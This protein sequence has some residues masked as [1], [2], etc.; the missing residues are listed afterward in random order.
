[1]GKESVRIVFKFKTT[2]L[3]IIIFLIVFVAHAQTFSKKNYPQ[4]YFQWPVGAAIGLAANFGELRRN[5][6]HMGLD[7]RTDQ[8]EN[9]PIYAAADGY[10][11]KVKIEPY[12]FG[13]G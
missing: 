13:N 5:H 10:V 1:M 4:N 9:R 7:C 6:W 8:M 12:G 2:F 11:A 3:A